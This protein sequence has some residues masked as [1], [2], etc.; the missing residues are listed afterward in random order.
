MAAQD[1]V[2]ICSPSASRDL[3]APLLAAGYRPQ[4]EESLAPWCGDGSARPTPGCVVI[5]IRADRTNVPDS[6]A[7]ERLRT[8]GA[9]VVLVYG[10]IDPRFAVLAMREGA[11]DVL[12]A[13]VDPAALVGAVAD[14]LHAAVT[15]HA[16][17]RR[18]A[19]ARELLASCTLREREIVVRAT[20][21]ERTKS[22]ARDLDC[23][24]STVK[25]H[26]SRA[27]RKMGVRSLADLIR[28]VEL[29]GGSSIA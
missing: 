20:R 8:G 19:R 16:D 7:W 11:S 5:E 3:V 12:S 25:V 2:V 28:L 9:R 17:A 1:T 21:G 23:Q 4:V 15:T 27:M 18:R 26:R 14:A 6:R 29:A 13:P 10:G 22:V 24:E